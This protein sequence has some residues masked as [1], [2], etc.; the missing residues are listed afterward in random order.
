MIEEFQNKKFIGSD[1]QEELTISL[2][3]GIDGKPVLFIDFQEFVIK[4]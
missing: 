2:Y 1:N 3:K 4:E